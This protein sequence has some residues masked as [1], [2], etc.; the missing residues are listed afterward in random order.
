MIARLCVN[1][2]QWGI[3]VT[4]VAGNAIVLLPSHWTL[5]FFSRHR[6]APQHLEIA[7]L[8]NGTFCFVDYSGRL[9][10]ES[11]VP[12]LPEP[13]QKWLEH[14]RLNAMVQH[15]HI[16]LWIRPE[17]SQ[18][19]IYAGAHAASACWEPIS[20]TSIRFVIPCAVDL[21]PGRYYVRGVLFADPPWGL[22]QNNDIAPDERALFARPVLPGDVFIPATSAESLFEVY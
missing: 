3:L 15:S 8:P 18:D 4:L 12:R 9:M 16:A 2:I 11:R 22:H 5:I 1:G 14:R 10:V 6:V 21:P 17:W 19:E 7:R 13:L 20:S